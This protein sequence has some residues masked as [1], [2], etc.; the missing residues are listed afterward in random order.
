MSTESAAK[1]RNAMIEMQLVARNIRD[2]AVL[3]AMHAVPRDA[4][5]PPECIEEAYEDRPLPIAHGQTISQPYMVALMAQAL[6]LTSQDRVLEIG[7]G[8]GYSAAVLSR[9]AA[10]V[11]TVER[12]EPLA[13]AT[14]DRLRR[15][16]FHNIHILNGDGTLGWPQ[17]A[18]Y[19]S[20]VVTAGGPSIPP[21]LRDQLAI[22]GRLV[23]PVGT[24]AQCQRLIRLT[25]QSPTQIDQEEL[26]EVRFVPLIG[27]QGW[28]DAEAQKQEHNSGSQEDEP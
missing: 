14:R 3:A 26:V 13:T 22:G 8:T 21:A 16:G 6:L 18:P 28:S 11:Y 19:D 2:P 4:F 12:L 25:R 15:L 23:M 9:I 24:S 7:A 20:I 5:V 10:D 1:K 17:Y 27:A